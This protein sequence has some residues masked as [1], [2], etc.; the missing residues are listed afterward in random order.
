MCRRS[1][2][3]IIKR[4]HYDSTYGGGIMW[5]IKPKRGGIDPACALWQAWLRGVLMGRTRG[6]LGSICL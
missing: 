1:N 2:H 4:R 3:L 5:L 6:Q